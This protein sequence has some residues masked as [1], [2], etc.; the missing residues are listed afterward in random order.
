MGAR[1][2]ITRATPKAKANGTKG[3]KSGTLDNLCSA[4]DR[5][6]ANA[7][8]QLLATASRKA[9][10]ASALKRHSRK[11][12]LAASRNLERTW[13]LEGE[14]CGKYPAAVTD[15]ALE[16]FAWFTEL[17]PLAGFLDDVVRE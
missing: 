11:D 12:S 5:S 2:E 9:G 16:R 3:Q 7:L 1:R 8:R 13:T 10:L 6:W 4:M 17:G 14:P 15:D